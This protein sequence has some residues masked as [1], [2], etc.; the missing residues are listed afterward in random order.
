[1]AR[2]ADISRKAVGWTGRDRPN[3]TAVLHL[4]PFHTPTAP[5]I[6]AAGAAM[7]IEFRPFLRVSCSY[8]GSDKLISQALTSTGLP[9]GSHSDKRWPHS[10]FVQCLWLNEKSRR[11]VTRWLSLSGGYSCSKIK[12]VVFSLWSKQDNLDIPDGENSDSVT[13]QPQD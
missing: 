3:L 4:A 5:Q 2:G 12:Y 7:C 6:K 8:Q 9:T 1:M 11:E 13:T 10:L